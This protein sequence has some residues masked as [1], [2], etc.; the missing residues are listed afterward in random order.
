MV[1]KSEQSKQ[2]EELKMKAEAD[3]EFFIRLIAPNRVLGGIHSELITWWSRPD[4]KNHQLVLLPRDHGKS[5]LLAYRVAWQL[6]RDPSTTFLYVSATSTLAEKQLYFIKNILTSPIYRQFWPEMVNRQES[7]REKWTNNEIMID[8]PYRKE[9]GIRDPSIFTAGLTTTI[10][11]L[12]FDIAAL[13]DVVVKENAYSGEGRTKVEEY[14]SLL[15]SIESGDSKEWA[16]GTRYHPTDLY[17]TILSLE[18]DIYDDSGEVVDTEPVYEVFQREVEDMGDGSGE[19]LWPRQQRD[20]GK[21]FG[22]DRQILA[23]KRAKYIDKAQFFA[24]YYNN[25]NAP[26]DEVI[27]PDLFQYYD[28]KFVTNKSGQWYY[29]NKRLNVVAAIDFAFSLKKKADYTALVV[30]GV[31]PDNNVYVLD[32]DRCKTDKISEYYAMIMRAYI[33]WNFKKLI[34]EASTAQSVII[35]EIKSNYLRPNGISLSIAEHK[36]TRH[37]GTKEERVL[38]T[39]EPKYSNM[40][41]W[42]YKGGHCQSLEDELKLRNPPHDDIKDALHA[43]VKNAVPP[44]E[45]AFG[46]KMKRRVGTHS[47]FGGVV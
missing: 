41:M 35:N 4:A 37:E 2:F 5:A 40:N 1:R 30:V 25:P 7:K 15:A 3:L 29:N 42:H 23:R 20:D 33:K 26:G 13:D 46:S 47:R 6:T 34:A 39:L 36:P 14:Y 24:Q 16:V 45:R 21:W 28:R 27:S 10:T 18:E 9:Q 19:F 17:N 11:G 43:A 38:A 44:S 22:F 12:H 32:I 31:D 8:H